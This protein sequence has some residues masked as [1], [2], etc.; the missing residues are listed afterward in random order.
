MTAPD[1]NESGAF[2][3]LDSTMNPVEAVREP[4]ESGII[5]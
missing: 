5:T 3:M 2:F 4:P 1:S